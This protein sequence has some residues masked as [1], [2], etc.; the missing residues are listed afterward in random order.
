MRS[1]RHRE[2]P[3]A[4]ARCGRGYRLLAD[5]EASRNSRML[6]VPLGMQRIIVP[7]P[8][9]NFGRAVCGPIGGRL[10]TPQ[11]GDLG[12]SLRGTVSR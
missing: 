9:A 10:E 7:S 2:A 12:P 3:G 4:V 5:C 1:P 11:T 6:T 8:A